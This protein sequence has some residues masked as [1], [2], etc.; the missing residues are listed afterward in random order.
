MNAF[1]IPEK[2][3]MHKAAAPFPANQSG[4]KHWRNLPIT[5]AK[6]GEIERNN[7]AKLVKPSI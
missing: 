6:Q 4:G 7:R 5:G 3:V 2:S 1:T